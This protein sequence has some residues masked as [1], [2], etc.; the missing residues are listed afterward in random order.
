MEL[1][2]A[3]FV[4]VMGAAMAGVWTRDIR[5]GVGFDAP[6]GLLRARETDTDDLM[7]WHWLAEY[8]TAGVLVAGAITLLAGAALAVP[9]TLLGLGA[10]IYTSANS[11]GWALSRSERRSYAIPMLIGLVGGLI[12]AVLLVL[13]T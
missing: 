9:I 12:S 1:L 13:A 11:L 5:S 6:Q 2:I 4:G 10:L 3:L 8:G 7:M